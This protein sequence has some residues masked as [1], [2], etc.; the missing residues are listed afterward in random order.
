MVQR[1]RA[2]F[3]RACSARWH[4]QAM[5]PLIPARA[6]EFT[7]RALASG[8]GMQRRG[9][10]SRYRRH[11][12]APLAFGHD[13]R[14]AHQTCDRLAQRASTHAVV[15]AQVL[16]AQLLVGQQTALD[17]VV[18]QARVGVL[19]QRARLVFA[20][21]F[22]G[23]GGRI[24]LCRRP[25]FRRDYRPEL[26]IRLVPGFDTGPR[27]APII[28]RQPAKVLEVATVGQRASTIEH[29]ALPCEPIAY[30][31]THQED[32]KVLQLAHLADTPHRIAGVLTHEFS[33]TLSTRF[34]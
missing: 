16:H 15:L 5:Q 14:V 11:S 3:V 32:R 24:A 4:G 34:G 27:L 10:G 8:G 30:A 2:G 18:T 13:Q 31:G 20:G 22:S 17:D 26:S 28:V 23:L 6:T 29:D 21:P 12:K 9:R 33:E 7:R 25:H 1:E 19:D